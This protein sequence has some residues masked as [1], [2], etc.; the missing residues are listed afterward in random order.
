MNM[1]TGPSKSLY[2]NRPLH[3][4][5]ASWWKAATRSM[6]AAIDMEVS[7]RCAGVAFYGFLSLFPAV[8]SAILVFGLVTD[9]DFIEGS[10]AQVLDLFPDQAQV[11]LRDQI[12]ALLSNNSSSLSIGLLI[13][14]SVAPWTGSRGANA[15]I[16][17]ISRAHH[18]DGIRSIV[19]GFLSSLT[20]TFG[21]FLVVLVSLF[22][23]AVVP[24]IA[25]AVPGERYAELVALWIRWPILLAI[26]FGAICVLYRYAPTRSPPRWTWVMPGALF[27][28]LGWLLTSFLFSTYVENFADYNTTFGALATPVILLLWFYYSTLIFIV[29]ATLNAELELQTRK[30]TTTGPSLPLGQRG[31]YVADNHLPR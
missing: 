15:L 31:A 8:A 26:I 12:V 21:V 29:G 19:G 5:G 3:L 7:M 11:I 10:Y 2:A 6:N 24:A 25:K 23:L 27:G 28:T 18:E 9:L 17:A 4:S 1:P 13:T 14:L 30:D 16:Y 22:G 20:T